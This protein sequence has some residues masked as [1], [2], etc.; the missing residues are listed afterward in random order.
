MGC[1]VKANRHGYLA[2]QLFWDRRR[3]WEGT[4]LRDTPEN[5]RKLERRAAAISDEMSEGR[6][7][8]RAR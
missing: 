4:G 3:T 6:F 5:R 7:D 8:V 2:Y 1:T